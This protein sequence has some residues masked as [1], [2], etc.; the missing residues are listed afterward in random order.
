MTVRKSKG[1]VGDCATE[2]AFSADKNV[3]LGAAASGLSARKVSARHCFRGSLG[4][5]WCEH[6]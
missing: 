5:C 3:V 6:V 1:N 4:E 2:P